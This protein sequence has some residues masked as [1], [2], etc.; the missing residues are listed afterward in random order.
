MIKVTVLM[1]CF[2]SNINI[3]KKSIDSIISQTFED[4]EF[5]IIDDGSKKEI[6]NQI[7][8]L[9]RVDKRIKLFQNK[10]NL[11]LAKSLNIGINHAQGEYIIRNDDDDYSEKNRIQA[12]VDFLE[13][14]PTI[15]AIG[16]NA[17]VILH[18]KKNSH[19]STN[20]PLSDKQ[21]EQA[22]CYTNPI[23][24]SSLCI[25]TEILKKF[26]YDEKYIYAQDY[27]LWINM[28]NSGVKFNNLKEKLI[29]INK[30]KPIKIK[31]FFYELKVKKNNFKGIK[32]LLIYIYSIFNFIKIVFNKIFY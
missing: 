1:S 24:H 12:Q 25:R 6:S 28:I 32:L 30:S 10:K 29:V 26:Y 14:N 21:I 2:N 5:L 19:Y 22:I 9:S 11:G 7:I 17:K 23:L 8:N 3:L 16:S 4:F 13:N 20:L 27:N 15:S 18:Y 31:N